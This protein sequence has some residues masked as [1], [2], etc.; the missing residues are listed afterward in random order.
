M[1]YCLSG[2]QLVCKVNKA[3]G[4]QDTEAKQGAPYT[5]ISCKHR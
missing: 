1:R 2:Q 3:L 5:A 4:K